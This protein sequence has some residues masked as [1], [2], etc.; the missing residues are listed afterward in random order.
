MSSG[1][2][3]TTVESPF[4]DQFIGI[5]WKLVTGNLDQLSVTGRDMF[6]EILITSDLRNAIVRINLREDKPSKVAKEGAT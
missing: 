2:E 3:L 6:R 4:I 1:R 5:G